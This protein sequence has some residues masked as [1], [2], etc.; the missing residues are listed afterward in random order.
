MNNQAT[1]DQL[2][3]LLKGMSQ[4]I[5]IGF[6]FIA[7]LGYLVNVFWT[8]TRKVPHACGENCTACAVM[9]QNS[10]KDK[11]KSPLP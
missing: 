6:M 9:N 5:I 4:E 2:N 8:R 1:F 7:A 10:T 11:F 3:A